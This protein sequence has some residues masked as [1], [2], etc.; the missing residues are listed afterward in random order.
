MAQRLCMAVVTFSLGIVLV[1]RPVHAQDTSAGGE[2]VPGDQ[3]TAAAATFNPDIARYGVAVRMPRWVSVPS[4]FLGLFTEENVPLSTFAAFG[5]EFIRRKGDLDIVVGV[6]YQKMGPAD[7][8]WLGKG[9]DPGLETDFVQF[10]NFGLLGVDASF[11]WRQQFNRY[12]GVHYGAGLGLALVQGKMLRISNAST[13]TRENAGDERAC[14]PII[15]PADGCTESVLR[16]SEGDIDNG[17]ANP[18]R[19]QDQ[20]VPGA[21]PI[22]NM[23]AGMSVRFPELRGFEAR[24]E[25]GFY[26]AFFVGMGLAYIFE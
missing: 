10:R 1:G 15:C 13:C 17:P 16:M 4:W 9:K 22:I 24:L 20:N 5:A 7:G 23:L 8:N 6:H 3:A 19:F 25:G 2:L 11:I 21:I 12:F 18:H 14:R 26:N